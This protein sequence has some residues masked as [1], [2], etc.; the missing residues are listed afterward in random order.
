VVVIDEDAVL[1][2]EEGPGTPAD[3]GTEAPGS[4]ERGSLAEVGDTLPS[5]EPR[6]RRWRL[7]RR[8]RD[9]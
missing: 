2:G 3:R 8:G 6:K 5:E 4:L 9:G 7:F 1:P